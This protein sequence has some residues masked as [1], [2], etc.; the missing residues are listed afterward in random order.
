MKGQLTQG[1]L[2]CPEILEAVVAASRRGDFLP[3][4][5]GLE[6]KQPQGTNS[7]CI[8]TGRYCSAELDVTEIGRCPD[9]SCFSVF[10]ITMIRFLAS[11]GVGDS[12][13]VLKYDEENDGEDY[14]LYESEI[15]RV[16]HCSQSDDI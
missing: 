16:S 9:G 3:N 15:E 11:G 8:K 12:Y 13:A 6:E 7:Y 10:D 4:F 14:D 2:E 5:V 1:F